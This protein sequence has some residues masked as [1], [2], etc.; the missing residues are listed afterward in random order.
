MA[1]PLN[2]PLHAARAALAYSID[3]CSSLVGFRYIHHTVMTT[4]SGIP[5]ALASPMGVASAEPRLE[6]TADSTPGPALM[7]LGATPAISTDGPGVASVSAVRSSSTA[8]EPSMSVAVP[9]DVVVFPSAAVAVFKDVV[10]F[11]SAAREVVFVVAAEEVVVVVAAEEVMVVVVA[12][13]V[14]GVV[15][16]GSM[17]SIRASAVTP[18]WRPA[19]LTVCFPGS[20]SMGML[21]M[22]VN[23][24]LASARIGGPTGLPSHLSLTCSE[25]SN[26]WPEI[27]SSSPA[28][29]CDG[30][31][32]SV[33][34]ASAGAASNT[35]ANTAA[36][37]PPMNP[38]QW[39]HNWTRSLLICNS[40]A[41]SEFLS[42]WRSTYGI[43]RRAHMAAVKTVIQNQRAIPA[44]CF[45]RELG[46]C[47]RPHSRRADDMLGCH[48][49]SGKETAHEPS[50][51]S[52][53]LVEGPIVVG[54]VVGA[55]VR[56]PMPHQQRRLHGPGQAA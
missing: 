15:A 33:P 45:Y 10:A 42:S 35:A 1:V 49:P 48:S 18:L 53:A 23:S 30:L 13:E 54:L 38:R 26:P 52:A 50:T 27:R 6:S 51:P 21:R 55:P 7:S 4:R 40:K 8:G 25:A 9:E 20:A 14:V 56:L 47:P 16:A 28:A 17:T 31:S 2:P 22:A 34:A 11:S 12:G 36:L 44:S 32:S 46:G 39:L 19:A 37:K 41:I 5:T 24:P 29:P 3:S 43:G